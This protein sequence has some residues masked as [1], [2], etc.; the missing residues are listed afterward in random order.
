MTYTGEFR[1]RGP[2]QMIHRLFSL[3]LKMNYYVKFDVLNH[4]G[5]WLNQE[6]NEIAPVETY[7][8][9]DMIEYR[10]TQ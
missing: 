9:A 6:L 2:V 3:E 4:S 8:L 10:F 5:G 1:K 7:P